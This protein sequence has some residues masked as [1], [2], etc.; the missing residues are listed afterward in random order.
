MS[1]KGS[2]GGD[3][4]KGNVPSRGEEGTGGERT[5]EVEQ[6]DMLQD[7]SDACEIAVNIL[8]DLLLYDKIED[9]SL[10]LE[11]QICSVRPFLLKG[12]RLFEIQVLVLLLVEVQ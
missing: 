11:K 10:T 4:K 6:K 3:G 1:D 5:K 9:G 2:G 7:L 12:I 8:D